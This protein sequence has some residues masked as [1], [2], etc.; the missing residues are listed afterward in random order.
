MT[1]AIRPIALAAAVTLV[2]S[3]GSPS[4]EVLDLAGSPN[5]S[6]SAGGS[7]VADR[8]SSLVAPAEIEYSATEE[9]LADPGFDTSASYAAWRLRASDFDTES[10]LRGVAGA[11]GVKGTV[12]NDSGSLVVTDGDASVSTYG[13]D[14]S[15]WW[16]LWRASAQPKAAATAPCEPVPVPVTPSPAPDATAPDSGSSGS[17][18]T[19]STV[20]AEP[21]QLLPPRNLPTEAEAR[22][23]VVAYMKKIGHDKNGTLEYLAG[24]DDWSTWVTVEWRLEGEVTGVSWYFSFGAD[25][26]LASAGGQ[27]FVASPAD[28]Y[29]VITVAQAV[30]RLNTGMYSMVPFGWSAAAATRDAVSPPASNGP[31]STGKTKVTLEKARLSL[32]NYWTA[33]GR[34]MLLPAYTFTGTKGES[35]QVL[36]VRD[37]YISRPVPSTGD[38]VV[39]PGS[40]GSGSSGGSS[41]GSPGIDVPAVA[42]RREDAE[43]L[44]GMDEEEAAKTAEAAGWTMRVTERDGESLMVTTDWQDNRVNVAVEDGRVSAVTSIG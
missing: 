44:V 24:S 15:R 28:K 11:L 12:R 43:K 1:R 41:T 20:C 7:E 8:M 31:S 13:D 30:E 19:G 14:N 27:F 42:V 23:R 22:S 36:A 5:A 4:A 37:E 34:Q 6:R 32:M 10:A 25:G 33:S 21:Q 3:C 38:V 2:A 35:I 16:S 17:G 39:D 18:T 29:R 26:V 9:L 40:P